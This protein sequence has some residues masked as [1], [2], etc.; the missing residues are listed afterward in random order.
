LELQRVAADQ[1]LTSGR[2]EEGAAILHSVLAAVGMRAPR[3]PLAALLR[4][5]VYQARLLA[6]GLHFE[7]RRPEDVS[8][9]DRLRVD[10]LFTVASS[11]TF[12]D[13]VGG[14]CM[15][16]RHLIEALRVG[17]RFQVLR[18][19][20]LEAAGMTVRGAR[21]TTRERAVLGLVRN[22]A[23]R[24]GTDEA[25]EISRAFL[26]LA[27]LQRGRWREAQRHFEV[28][29]RPT[30]AMRTGLTTARIFAVYTWFFLGDLQ[31]NRTRI[32][33]LCADAE[34]R[35]DL[36]TL[37]NLSVPNAMRMCLAEDDP[38]G[39]RRVMHDALARWTQK[40]FHVQR[41]LFMAHIGDIDLYVGEGERA[42]VCFRRELPR[43]RRSLLMQATQVRVM[44]R[45]AR[46]RLAIASIEQRP[47]RRKARIAEAR[48][49][50]RRLEGE[51]DR[52]IHVLAEMAEAMVANAAGDRRAAIAALRKAVARADETETVVYG[53]SARYR[54]GKLL[55]GAEGHELLRQTR[56]EMVEQGIRKP[57]RWVAVY[58]P[59][60]WV[61]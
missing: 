48:R 58:M 54:L 56:E 38:D 28:F 3:T 57:E 36:Y 34:D 8:R 53:L 7:E 6:M 29:E 42:Y 27:L 1:L 13:V 25:R 31:E 45:F 47:E 20:S 11:F 60:R 49:M 16:A 21:E 43:L 40:G 24:I 12:V 22:L 55:G 39:A 10:A 51:H 23:E 33:R 17:D 19:M 30:L 4:L 9:E 50:A 59:G 35:G 2:I 52:W 18:A 46:A 41:W 61:A 26:G 14:L 15:Q 5:G 32:E 44:T 37:V